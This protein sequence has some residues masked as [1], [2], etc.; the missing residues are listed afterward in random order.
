MN[1]L[2]PWALSEPAVTLLLPFKVSGVPPGKTRTLPPRGV[3]YHARRRSPHAFFAG[4]PRP[5]SQER[6]R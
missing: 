6:I 2:S 3:A 5:D 1:A 4:P